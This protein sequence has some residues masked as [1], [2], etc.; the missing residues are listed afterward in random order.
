[1]MIIENFIS[2]FSKKYNCS[3][4]K[5]NTEHRLFFGDIDFTCFEA[6]GKFNVQAKICAL[7]TDN[8][9]RM[10]TYQ[11]YLR[12]ALTHIKRYPVSVAVENDALIIFYQLLLNRLDYNLFENIVEEF[13]NAIEFFNQVEPEESNFTYEALLIRP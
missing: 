4:V 11:H 8:E 12:L 3:Y 1:M 7:P 5:D 13:I 9:E 6:S 2:E 10:V